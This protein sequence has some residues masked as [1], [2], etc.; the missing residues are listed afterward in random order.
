VLRTAER[1][2][3]YLL[4]LFRRDFDRIAQADCWV[5]VHTFEC[6]LKESRKS[7]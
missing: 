7:H 3:G 5:S 6:D 4:E 2:Q 1:V